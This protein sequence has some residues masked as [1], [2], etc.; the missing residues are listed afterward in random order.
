[1]VS[2]AGFALAWWMCQE[3]IRLDE[4]VSL[5]VAGAVLATLLTVAAWWASGGGDSG[6]FDDDAV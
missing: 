5:G 1:V 4:G 2:V 3:L 6:G